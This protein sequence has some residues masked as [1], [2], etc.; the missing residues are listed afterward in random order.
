MMKKIIILLIG[1]FLSSFALAQV[2]Q[3]YSETLAKMFEL[4]G[5]EQI[6]KAVLQQSF[7]MYRQQ[8][9]N[10]DEEMWNELKTEFLKTSINDLV[11]ML[12]PVYQKYLTRED[13]NKMIQ[14]YQTPAGKKFAKYQPA[15]S[16]ESMQIGQQW[17]MEIGQKFAKKLEQEGIK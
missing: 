6:Y 12:V 11:D 9:P 8:Y 13:L 1:I 2:N 17:G 14:F 10:V 15:I 16:K 5:S 7:S 4:A 3:E